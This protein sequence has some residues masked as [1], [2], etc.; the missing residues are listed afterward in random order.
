MCKVRNEGIEQAKGE[1]V[2]LQDSDDYSLPDRVERIVDAIGDAD[3]LV[4]GLY[5]NAWN[6][7]YQCMERHYHPPKM[8][9]E[10]LYKEQDV[11]GVAVFK[12]AWWVKHPFQERFKYVFDWGMHLDWWLSGAKYVTLDRGLYEYVRYQGSSS[13]RFE[14]QGLRAQGYEQIKL[15]LK[16]HGRA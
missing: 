2:V 3:V 14:K 16:E 4:H 5:T 1:I 7:Q 6:E 10:N 12:K 13:D 9:S 11:N 15:F 8:P